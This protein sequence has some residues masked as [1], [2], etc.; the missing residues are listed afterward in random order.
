MW[1]KTV[2]TVLLCG[3]ACVRAQENAPPGFIRADLVSWTGT[4]NGQIVFHAAAADRLYTCSYDE[5]T[6]IERDNERITLARAE[7]G[8]HLEIVSDRRLGSPTCYARTMHVVDPQPSY[9]VPGVRP[10]LRKTSAGSPLFVPHP[11]LSL[12]GAV[13]R[14][15]SAALIVRSPSGERTVIRLRPDTR[16]FAEGQTADAASLPVNRVVYIRGGRNLYDELEAY[17][18][19]W[20]EI[21]QPVP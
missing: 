19:I 17:Q 11:N 12:S 21:L 7:K 6:Y 3:M 18:V 5:K 16:Y 2:C 9:S 14:M 15:T 13:V 1:S 8:D 4:R 10:R 20:G